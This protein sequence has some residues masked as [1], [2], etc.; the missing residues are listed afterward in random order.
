VLVINSSGL[1]IENNRTLPYGEAWQAENTPSTNDKKF[2]TYL[3]DQESGLDYAMARYYQNNQ[4][5]MNSPDKGPIRLLAPA[6]LNRY[7]YGISDPINNKDG[8]GNVVFPVWAPGDCDAS[9]GG[10][11]ISGGYTDPSW[12]LVGGDSWTLLGISYFLGGACYYPEP[13]I[14]TMA[15]DQVG[16][17]GGAG[18]VAAPKTWSRMPAAQAAAIKGLSNPGCSNLFANATATGTHGSKDPIVVLTQ[19]IA[20]TSKYGKLSFGGLPKGTRAQTTSNIFTRI[21]VVTSVSI[22]INDSTSPGYWDNTGD[23]YNG[24]T[25]LHELAHMYNDLRSQLGGFAIN[26]EGENKDPYVFDKILDQ[27]CFGG[28]F[29]AAGKPF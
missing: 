6:T 24:L 3:R 15:G 11:L 5:R 29:A 2:T 16:G 9:L 17:G 26:S 22:V 7:T 27:K 28:S 4:G 13:A 23:D 14:P 21:G 8:S 1:V 18:P 25:L 12:F 20:G 10:Q 19:L